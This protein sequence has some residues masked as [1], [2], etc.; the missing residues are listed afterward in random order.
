MWILGGWFGNYEACPRDVW[1][2]SDGTSWKLVEKTAPW[3]HGDPPMTLVFEDKIWFTGGWY[4]GKLPG[5][6]A[7]NED[8]W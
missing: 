3:K 8:W 5:H 6:S 4:N 1:N 2:S 7:S